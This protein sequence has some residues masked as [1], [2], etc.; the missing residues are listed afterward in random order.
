[1]AVLTQTVVTETT[2]NWEELAQK[3]KNNTSG[4]KA[5]DI[6]TEKTLDGE[7]MDL[8]VVDMG[9][10]WAR[11]ESK[12]CLPVEVAYNDNNRNAGGFAD[13]DV[14]H[15][16]NEVVFNNLPE[17]L[18]NVIAEVERK[19]ENGKSSLCR[20]FLPTESEMFG[21]CCYS[22]DDTYSQI[23]YYKDR[24]NRIKCNRKGGS[25]DWYWLA[26]V[27]SGN[28][29]DCVDVNGNG[30]SYVWGASPELYVPVCFVIQ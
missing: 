18:R 16:L 26:S 6:I 12:D 25:P 7:E 13:S 19:Q 23:E 15:Y 4:L 30:N 11:F 8:V 28:S 29:A 9:P 5:G 10:C 3:I 17:D 24:R 27:R 20:L 21:D 1:M 22:E 2:I 14:K